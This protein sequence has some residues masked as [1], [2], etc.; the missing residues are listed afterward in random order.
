MDTQQFLTSVLGSGSHY[1]LFGS[2]GDGRKIQRFYTS[3]EALVRNA[4]ALDSK[5]ADAYYGVA[6]F[7]S[8][9]SRKAANVEALA[10]LFLDL[11]CG[12]DKD[13][14]DKPHAIR[15][16]RDFCVSSATR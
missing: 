8:D 10:A 16:L 13:F 7:A 2:R 14:S 4:Q 11:D 6:R 3:V 12:P 9:E 15:A 1:C 5:G